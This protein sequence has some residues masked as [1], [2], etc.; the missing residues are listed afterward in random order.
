M[1]KFVEILLLFFHSYHKH[2][3]LSQKRTELSLRKSILS[4]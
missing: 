3:S 2:V 4:F 1:P